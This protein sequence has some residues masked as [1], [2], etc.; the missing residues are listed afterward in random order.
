MDPLIALFIYP[1][2]MALWCSEQSINL[3]PYC[4]SYTNYN[5]SSVIRKRFC[6]VSSSSSTK[7]YVRTGTDAAYLY[8][9]YDTFV[10]VSAETLQLKLVLIAL[11]VRFNVVP[12]VWTRYNG[13]G[14]DLVWTR[15]RPGHD[16][17]IPVWWA[18]YRVWFRA[19]FFLA[20]VI[21]FWRHFH[22]RALD[23]ILFPCLI[24]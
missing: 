14:R 6:D 1:S 11:V 8:P 2:T 5:R 23:E 7:N 4:I 10:D 24:Q 18:G 15:A 9:S 3:A 19:N 22:G 17:T 16:V 12:I 13:L 20:R 21:Q